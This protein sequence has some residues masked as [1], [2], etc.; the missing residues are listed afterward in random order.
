MAGGWAQVGGLVR[1]AHADLT[2]LASKFPFATFQK[3]ESLGASRGEKDPETCSN[4]TIED[5]DRRKFVLH[6]AHTE[7]LQN[8]FLP[9]V[10]VL[11]I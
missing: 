8:I 6:I 1:S 5:F 4:Q 9:K 10:L 2:R 11:N 3:E 7:T